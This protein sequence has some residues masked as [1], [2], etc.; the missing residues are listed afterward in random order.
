MKYQIVVWCVIKLYIKIIRIAS[1]PEP[2]PLFMKYLTIAWWSRDPQ[3]PTI[4]RCLSKNKKCEVKNMR[5]REKREL[6]RVPVA[7]NATVN[8]FEK[9]T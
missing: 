7:I 6:N 1:D 8:N 4:S 3:T 2:L 5:F 9:L